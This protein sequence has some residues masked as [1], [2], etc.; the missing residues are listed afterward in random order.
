MLLLD[1]EELVDPLPQLA[2]QISAHAVVEHDEPLLVELPPF[3]VRHEAH[4]DAL[5]AVEDRKRLFERLFERRQ[6]R[7]LD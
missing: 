2:Q 5:L 3:P 4:G 7:D 6:L 1:V